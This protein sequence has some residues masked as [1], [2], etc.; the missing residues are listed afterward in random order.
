MFKKPL[1]GGGG[2]GGGDPTPLRTR[3]VKIHLLTDIRE[4][5]LPKN[6]LKKI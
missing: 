4:N 5:F 6:I 1:E 3:R 2:G